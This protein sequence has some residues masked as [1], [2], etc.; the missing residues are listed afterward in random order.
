MLYVPVSGVDSAHW[1]NAGSS[2]YLVNCSSGV[3]QVGHV[4]HA[5]QPVGTHH[6]VQLGPHLLCHLGVVDHVQD[7]PL[8][9]CLQGLDSR[10]KDVEENLLQL[11]LWVEAVEDLLQVAVL[12]RLLN[13]QQVGVDQ[14]P[15]L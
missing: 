7:C 3:R 10:R 2:L 6:L 9:C 5:G 4:L 11:L 13:L 14:V 1:N 15:W 12:G 8:D